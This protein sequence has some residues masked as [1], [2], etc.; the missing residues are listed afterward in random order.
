MDALRRMCRLV[1]GGFAL[2]FLPPFMCIAATPA[3]L[4]LGFTGW[5]LLLFD[6]VLSVPLLLAYTFRMLAHSSANHRCHPRVEQ[7]VMRLF[8]WANN[9]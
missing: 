6:N 9:T 4:V 5:A 2:G 7:K 3:W 1:L 8:R